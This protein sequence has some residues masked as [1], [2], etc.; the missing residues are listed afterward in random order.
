MVELLVRHGASTDGYCDTSI[1]RASP[2]HLAAGLDNL[3]V[4]EHLIQGGANVNAGAS[5][6]GFSPLYHAVWAGR[7]RMVEYLLNHGAKVALQ[8]TTAPLAAAIENRDL[9]MVRL[10]L[11]AGADPNC[12]ETHRKH[13]PIHLASYSN[14][15]PIVELLVD[16]G[17]RVNEA[18]LA[19]R[20]ATPL[21][22]AAARGYR[23]LI[24]T[25]LRLGADPEARAADGFTP[26]HSASASGQLGSAVALVEDGAD[27]TVRTALGA[28]P[29]QL[30]QDKGHS[31][32]V[33][34]L[35][36]RSSS[37]DNEFLGSVK[38]YL[39]WSQRQGHLVGAVYEW[40]KHLIGS[41]RVA[42]VGTGS[43]AK[44]T[45]RS[46]SRHSEPFGLEMGMGL[47]DLTKMAPIREQ[48][49]LYAYASSELSNG[50]T[51]MVEYVF[52][53]TPQHG[54][55][56]VT[57]QTRP[58]R[59]SGD[60]SEVRERFER[61]VAELS[62]KYGQ[63]TKTDVL[64]E[65]SIWNEPNWWM[66]TLKI[67]ERSLAANWPATRQRPLPYNLGAV[68]VVAFAESDSQG[69]LSV[70]YSSLSKEECIRWVSSEREKARRLR[71]LGNSQ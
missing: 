53:I 17:A 4:V 10:L 6:Q 19:D 20:R 52:I 33:E 13:C 9:E 7:R 8:R 66:L 5:S 46:V 27:W 18:T 58:I 69:G 11:D 35:R 30:A 42:G 16:R 28:T 40:T 55:C 54:L 43:R 63:A 64:L 44:P 48:P 51:E 37:G 70:T 65:D 14:I 3:D 39:E 2:I 15:P 45:A 49:D 59:T 22:I 32:I 61:L 38:E 26:L 56:E 1:D 47:A 62:K 50:P 23:E 41:N 12:D 36:N 71:Y 25:L 67:G 29:L 68:S 21:H 34:Y 24:Q 57:A 31:F 60:G